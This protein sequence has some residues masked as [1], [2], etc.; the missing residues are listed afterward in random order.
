MAWVV[1]K[2]SRS[3]E[4]INYSGPTWDQAF[5]R[6]WWVPQYKSRR[7]AY[8]VAAILNMHNPVGFQ[9][10]RVKKVGQYDS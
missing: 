1:Y 4:R 8:L 3:P 7:A 9:I 6:E 10:A 5:P 2:G